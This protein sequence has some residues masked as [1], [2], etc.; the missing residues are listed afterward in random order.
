MHQD[1]DS[2]VDK[3]STIRWQPNNPVVQHHCGTRDHTPWTFHGEGREDHC[4]R[5]PAG[6]AG[7]AAAV[8]ADVAFA[9]IAVAVAL[10][11]RCSTMCRVFSL[12][13]LFC[14]SLLSFLPHFSPS[15]QIRRRP[16]AVRMCG[17]LS[18]R[19]HQAFFHH[20]MS[21]RHIIRFMH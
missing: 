10:L 21:I 18:T 15:R 3:K 12:H 5:I 16:L 20:V 6:T 11:G 7:A 1:T 14:P 17:P 19:L 2:Q 13:C 8:A 9:L 4:H